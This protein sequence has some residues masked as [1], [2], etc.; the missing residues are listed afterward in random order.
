MTMGC[1]RQVVIPR[2]ES[3]CCRA[4]VA[5]VVSA[6]QLS[7]W[8]VASRRSSLTCQ[9]MRIC[10]QIAFKQVCRYIQVRMK[11][12]RCCRA[13]APSWR[14][15]K[16]AGETQA[17][18]KS[19]CLPM[20]SARDPRAS[21]MDSCGDD[22]RSDFLPATEVDADYAASNGMAAY[23]YSY[24]WASGWMLDRKSPKR[25]RLPFGEAGSTHG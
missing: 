25:L 17:D 7:H 23:C 12:H 15:P 21:L 2:V 19:R 6:E 14:R 20:S 10:G 4:I 16:S 3:R 5:L 18:R 13:I 1:D 11:S 22:A 9:A 8:P 24:A